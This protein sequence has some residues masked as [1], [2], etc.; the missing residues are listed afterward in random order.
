MNVTQ[1]NQF[2]VDKKLAFTAAV[3]PA[4]HRH[5]AVFRTQTAIG[6]VNR[7]RHF[8]AAH[9]AAV[10]RTCKDN[11]LHFGAT[12]RLGRLF[13]QD[14]ADCIRN[15]RLSAA[16]RADN[17]RNAAVEFYMRPVRERFEP[18]DIKTF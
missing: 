12:Q 13:A 17:S 15:I 4:G 2:S 9:R 16:I 3:I 1:A 11:V 8:C 6:I 10:S 7:Q 18:L 14:P 5:F